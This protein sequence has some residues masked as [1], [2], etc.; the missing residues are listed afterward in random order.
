MGNN[1]NDNL[2][3]SEDKLKKLEDSELDLVYLFCQTFLEKIASGIK[4]HQLETEA[5]L[6]KQTIHEIKK[7]RIFTGE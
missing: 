6:M 4:I 5:L 3:F 7:N 1:N 2:D